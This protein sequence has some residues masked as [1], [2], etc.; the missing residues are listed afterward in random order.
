MGFRPSR[1]SSKA[2]T[3]TFRRGSASRRSRTS[4]ASFFIYRLLLG[5]RRLGVP[6]P[7]HLR[8]V[9]EPPEVVPPPLRPHLATEPGRHPHRDLGTGPQ[10]AVGGRR[11]QRGPQRRLALRVQERPRAPVPPP[12]VTPTVPPRRV[13]A[14]H[15]RGHP[16]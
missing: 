2:H 7:W 12:P 13:G 10:A 14:A 8:A 16:D 6:R 1:C 5:A 11:R 4:S 3:S 15:R 9:A